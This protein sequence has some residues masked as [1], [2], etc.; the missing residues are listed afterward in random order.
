MDPVEAAVVAVLDD[1]DP[2]L[3]A[4]RQSPVASTA[5]AQAAVRNFISRSFVPRSSAF[6]VTFVQSGH[7]DAGNLLHG[8]SEQDGHAAGRGGGLFWPDN[9]VLKYH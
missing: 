9:L 6:Q 3:Q 4:A 2:L 5:T 7:L 8:P 1:D